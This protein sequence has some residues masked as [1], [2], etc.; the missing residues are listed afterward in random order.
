MH[1]QSARKGL[2]PAVVPGGRGDAPR[3]FVESRSFDC[4]RRHRVIIL[5]LRTFLLVGAGC[6]AGAQAPASRI[7]GAPAT[8]CA[9]LP[10]RPGWCRVHNLPGFPKRI[11]TRDGRCFLIHR[12][13]V[14]NNA[15][16]CATI[17]LQNFTIVAVDRDCQGGCRNREGGRSFDPHLDGAAR[18]ALHRDGIDGSEERPI[19]CAARH[20]MPAI[21]FGWILASAARSAAHVRPVSRI[22]EFHVPTRTAHILHDDTDLRGRQDRH[23]RC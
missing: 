14:A 7:V 6:A 18:H 4:H 22:E 19:R 21:R 17:D 1:V 8:G 15:C 5:L 12:G 10:T 23:E 20:C 9:R 2:R 3:A 11:I 16:A 13:R